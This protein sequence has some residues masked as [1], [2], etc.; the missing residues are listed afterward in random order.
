MKSK[1]KKTAPK[2]KMP[3]L[4]LM[5]ST[6]LKT[7]LIK[8]SD[9]A[10]KLNRSTSTFAKFKKQDS[11][12]TS[13]LW[14]MCHALEHNFFADLANQ[15]PSHFTQSANAQTQLMNDLHEKI[16]T[17]EIEKNMLEKLLKK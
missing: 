1:L 9:L 8:S 16:K 3:S 5:L 17:L 15:L 12:Q 6:Y 7:N 13:I 2:N 14:E 4:G 11:F 10:I